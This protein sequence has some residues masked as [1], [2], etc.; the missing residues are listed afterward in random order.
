MYHGLVPIGFLGPSSMSSSLLTLMCAK[1]LD[2]LN[3]FPL[4]GR[5]MDKPCSLVSLTMHF[6]SGPS[7]HKK[8]PLYSRVE[9]VVLARHLL[10][11]YMLLHLEKTKKLA[12]T[13]RANSEKY[14]FCKISRSFIDIPFIQAV[15]IDLET[16]I[17]HTEL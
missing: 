10:F 2:N 9:R 17:R 8:I 15:E 12:K 4:P 16:L 7:H 1:K 5:L 6:V 13:I 14:R 3:V 11:M